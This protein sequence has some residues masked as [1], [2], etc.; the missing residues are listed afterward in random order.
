MQ[1][2]R[3]NFVIIAAQNYTNPSCTTEEEFHEDL[4]LH[5]SVKKLA[6]RI[7][8]GNS[9]NLRLLTNHVICF[10]NSFEIEFAK[11]ALLLGTD[12]REAGVI[13]SILV[14]LGFLARHEYQVEELDLEAVRLLK[15][16]DNG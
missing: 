3:E 6:K 2:T 5:N 15:D 13:K 7:S 10:T 8:K 14:Y 16:M 11:E 1:L 12:P 4:S 9:K